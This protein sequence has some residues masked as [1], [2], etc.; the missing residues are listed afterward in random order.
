ME[1]RIVQIA[2]HGHAQADLAVHTFEE[3]QGE[4][5]GDA[6]LLLELGA[7]GVT[8]LNPPDSNLIADG[9]VA[10]VVL[11]L[12]LGGHATPTDPLPDVLF[13]VWVDP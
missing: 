8:E 13:C 4:L 11:I 12:H 3:R 2:L 1:L 6:D 5:E 7:Q 10:G 9:E